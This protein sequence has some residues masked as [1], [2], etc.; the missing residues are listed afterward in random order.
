MEFSFYE[1]IDIDFA[2]YLYIFL[3]RVLRDGGGGIEH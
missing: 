2:F 3:L 1:V